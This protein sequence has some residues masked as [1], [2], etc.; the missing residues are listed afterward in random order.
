MALSA[1][2][3]GMLNVPNVQKISTPTA[4]FPQPIPSPNKDFCKFWRF[5]SL[6]GLIYGR[7]ELKLGVLAEHRRYIKYDKIHIFV[8]FLY[9]NAFQ[10]KFS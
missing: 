4:G 7:Q 6:D 1:S 8:F 2:E 5:S 10:Q 9:D 3:H